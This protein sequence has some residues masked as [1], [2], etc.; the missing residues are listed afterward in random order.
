MDR[1]ARFAYPIWAL[2]Y[3]IQ[4]FAELDEIPTVE[5]TKQVMG[6]ATTLLFPETKT[7]AKSLT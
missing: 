5:P 4:F 1:K 7:E 3:K 6:F 2:L